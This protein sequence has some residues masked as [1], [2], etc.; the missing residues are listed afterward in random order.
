[1]LMGYT[2]KNSYLYRKKKISISQISLFTIYKANRVLHLCECFWNHASAVSEERLS[3]YS[4]F[5]LTVLYKPCSICTC[6]LF[7]GHSI[8]LCQRSFKKKKKKEKQQ[9]KGGCLMVFYCFERGSLSVP[10]WDNIF[11][12]IRFKGPWAPRLALAVKTVD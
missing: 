6:R 7:L 11:G 9:C 2:G 5:S 8:W 3:Y 1:M 12:L 4:A 10:I